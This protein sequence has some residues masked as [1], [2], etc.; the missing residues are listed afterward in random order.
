MFG[1]FFPQAPEKGPPLPSGLGLKW[2]WVHNPG[3]PVDDPVVYDTTLDAEIEEMTRR[4]RDEFR[5]KGYPPGL[6]ERA[7]LWA[8]D[9]AWGLP[10]VKAAY[11]V[12]P[13]VGRQVYR[14]IYSQA[15]ALSNRWIESLSRS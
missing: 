8:K 9:W 6:T 3:N 15:L 14:G 10:G 11:D 12:S 2:P 1:Q 7:L 13:E 5:A 4:K